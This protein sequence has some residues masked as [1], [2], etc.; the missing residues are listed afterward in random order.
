MVAPTLSMSGRAMTAR[1]G[2]R[3]GTGQSAGSSGAIVE[4]LADGP[5]G[6]LESP[7]ALSYPAIHRFA[8][9]MTTATDTDE[10]RVGMLYWLGWERARR[11]ASSRDGRMRVCPLLRSDGRQL[12]GVRARW[13]TG[14][15]GSR[16]R[17][18]SR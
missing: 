1:L 5:P 2:R 18:V 11:F 6:A 16:G 9:D 15:L 8:C 17:V 3:S 7:D 13:R 10:E 12:P 14:W 4:R